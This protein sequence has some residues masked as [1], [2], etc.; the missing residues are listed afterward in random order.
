M[1]L[2]LLSRNFFQKPTNQI[3]KDLLGK[4]LVRAFPNKKELIGKIVET[5]SYLFDDPASH[6]FKGKTPRNSQMFSHP[7]TSYVYFTYGMYHCFNVVTNKKGIGEAVLIRAVEPVEGI[8]K[9]KKNRR[10]EKVNDLTNGPAKLTIAF[11]IDK[12]LNGVDLLSENSELRIME[13]GKKE[14]FEIVETE[15]IGIS[16]GAES[17]QRF[18][19][20]GNG[21][22]S[23]KSPTKTL[24]NQN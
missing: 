3:A 24:K 11:G 7:G 22:V 6:S 17:L 13:D 1:N 12:S 19:I 9:M 8:E 4:Y 5:E 20:K 10:K 21:F 2:R 18:F 15:R 14:K 23:K 16:V